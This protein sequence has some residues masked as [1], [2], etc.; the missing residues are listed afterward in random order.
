MP[1]NEP[2]YTISSATLAEARNFIQQPKP[3]YPAAYQAAATDLK[4]QAAHGVKID[5]NTIT[6][7]TDAAQINDPHGTSFLHYFVR[8]YVSDYAKLTAEKTIDDAQF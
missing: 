4:T 2:V 8:D 3:D 6:W 1:S 5:P 7:Y